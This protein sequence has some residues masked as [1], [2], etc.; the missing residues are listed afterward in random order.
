[1]RRGPPDQAG[2]ENA[3]GDCGFAA[4]RMGSQT[5]SH[6]TS[7]D[8]GSTAGTTLTCTQS[9]LKKPLSGFPARTPATKLAPCSLSG[10]LWITPKGLLR[11]GAGVDCAMSAAK[12]CWKAFVNMP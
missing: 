6:G 2:T 5:L 10:K 11:T 3:L 9:V 8:C 4:N 7:C 12:N 1:S